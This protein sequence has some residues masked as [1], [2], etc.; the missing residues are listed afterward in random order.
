MSNSTISSNSDWVKD[1]SGRVFA[2]GPGDWGSITGRVI[3][4]T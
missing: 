2:K 4:K 1:T 3:P